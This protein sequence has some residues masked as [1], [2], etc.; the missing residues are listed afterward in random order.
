MKTLMILKPD[1]LKRKVAGR[2]L[3]KV[4]DAGFVVRRL[5]LVHLDEAR[6]RKFYAVHEGK[7]FMD[8]LVSYMTSGPCVPMA[9]EAEN[10]VPR[11]RELMGATNPQNA[12]PGTIRQEF[13]VDIQTNSVHGSD[14]P[15]NAAVEI[16]FFFPGEA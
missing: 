3:A 5:E 14:S 2:I 8:E 11:L 15:E 7:P 10:A 12:A 1:T 4:E 9:L 13:G 6:A 16:T